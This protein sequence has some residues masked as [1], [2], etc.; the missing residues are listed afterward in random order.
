MMLG[1]HWHQLLHC[2]NCNGL[3]AHR[4]QSKNKIPLEMQHSMT[5]C[6]PIQLSTHISCRIGA[7]LMMIRISDILTGDWC[8]RVVLLWIHRLAYSKVQQQFT[9]ISVTYMLWIRRCSKALEPVC[10]EGAKGS[11]S[12]RI[13]SQ[14]SS[15]TA[16]RRLA[17]IGLTGEWMDR[18]THVLGSALHQCFCFDTRLAMLQRSSC[19]HHCSGT[20]Q[21]LST[22]SMNTA[23]PPHAGQMYSIYAGPLQ[24][25]LSYDAMSRDPVSIPAGLMR[26]SLRCDNRLPQ[27][28]I[29]MC[30]LIHHDLRQHTTCR[31]A[32]ARR[33]RFRYR[34]AP[35]RRHIRRK[36]RSRWGFHHVSCSLILWGLLSISFRCL[37][38]QFALFEPATVPS[39]WN[40]GDAHCANM[41]QFCSCDKLSSS[42]HQYLSRGLGW[43]PEPS[44]KRNLY[45]MCASETQTFLENGGSTGLS[46]NF[47]PTMDSLFRPGISPG[48]WE[49]LWSCFVTLLLLIF[50]YF[51]HSSGMHFSSLFCCSDRQ[52]RTCSRSRHGQS[53]MGITNHKWWILCVCLSLQ[54]FGAS[55]LGQST[56]AVPSPV[57]HRA[58][59]VLSTVRKRSYKRACVRAENQ[60]ATWYRGRFLTSM[61][62]RGRSRRAMTSEGQPNIA[63]KVNHAPIV[64][65]AGRYK[66]LTWNCSGLQAQYDQLVQWLSCHYYDIVV[67]QETFWKF[68]SQWE[69]SR[70]LYV[71]SG[72]QKIGR[73][74]GG[75][76]V[77]ISRKLTDPTHV[78]YHEVVP[79]RLLRVHFPLSGNPDQTVDILGLYQYAWTSKANLQSRHDLW[80]KLSQ[81]LHQTSA[82]SLLLVMGDFNLTCKGPSKHVGSGTPKKPHLA[83]DWDELESI[84]IAH[85]LVAINTFGKAPGYTFKF[86]TVQSQ[87][88]YILMRLSQAD[89]VSRQARPLLNFPLS[90]HNEET[91]AKHLPVSATID[92]KWLRHMSFAKT[93]P[94]I[95]VA[96]L[97]QAVQSLDSPSV[98]SLRRRVQQWVDKVDLET[99][100]I[101]TF[102]QEL[103]VA[104]QEATQALFSKQ[105]ISSTKPWQDE[106]QVSRAKTM[107]TLF[108]KM[109]QQPFTAKGIF[110]A[111]R[112][113][114]KFTEKHREHKQ[115]SR[116]LR[117]CKHRAILRDAQMAA[118]RHDT[119]ELY[120]IVRRLAPKQPSTKFQIHDKGRLLQPQEE[121]ALFSKHY[122]DLYKDEQACV[123]QSRVLSGS[124]SLSVP[125]MTF[126]LQHIPLRKA[127]SAK[128][129]PGAS[130]R[131]CADILAPAMVQVLCIAWTPYEIAI[132][133]RWSDAQLILLCKPNKPK[134]ELKSW[135]P[136]GLQCPVAKAT[137]HILV[138]RVKPFIQEWA[139]PLPLFA[140]LSAR[141]TSNA[142]RRVFHHCSQVRQRCLDH[143]DN[144]HHRFAGKRP[145]NLLGGLQASLDLSSAFD[146]VP[147]KYIELALREAKVPPDLIHI[148]MAWLEKSTYTVQIAGQETVINVERGV[149]AVGL[150]LSCFL[151]TWP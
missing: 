91:S 16:L 126:Y 105:P 13:S 80:M 6:A 85:H 4:S 87:L 117:I 39:P 123:S 51:T 29:C 113:W 131:A 75:V 114:A 129:A 49:L 46:S 3:N 15:W 118:S 42:L 132:P 111:W 98:Q 65:S 67:V 71:H 52:Q 44:L 147:W 93:Q 56:L 14:V 63:Q 127:V 125:Q 151:L 37:H 68:S 101:D 55:A 20:L 139:A 95:D 24:G 149:K 76:L 50:G 124:F 112:C 141:N 72:F 36:P 108:R 120:R 45:S 2:D 41:T 116:Q 106:V 81:T 34:P 60:G 74:E 53:L 107:W 102:H 136:I 138:D 70:Y 146:K 64:S 10:A 43:D 32:L 61:Q 8:S 94:G 137:M 109:R 18:D 128:S 35:Y 38:R 48:A 47:L 134:L 92:R 119:W 33:W 84:L 110:V 27:W 145:Q 59:P 40:I 89:K 82:R 78:R 97:A 130:Y 19:V 100:S 30:V 23:T 99:I 104:M 144:L 1:P 58:E 115:R 122:T 17:C 12:R 96:Q 77:V 26:S 90:A 140:Y 86:N 28:R 83:T 143:G 11:E 133:Q 7:V 21:P 22:S 103:D 121:L 5:Q 135:R 73:G 25:S 88:D 9:E 54:F 142:L 150:H 79:G 148:I 62:L 66:I 57:H 31:Y 69:D